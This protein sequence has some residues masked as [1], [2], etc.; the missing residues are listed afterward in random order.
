MIEAAWAFAVLVLLAAVTAT[1]LVPWQSLLEIGQGV[2]LSASAVG[3]PLEIV[4]FALLGLALRVNGGA[5]QGWYWRSFLHHHLLTPSQRRWVL[6]WFY[7]GA[8]AFLCIG[9]GI[10]LVVLAFV[11]AFRQ[12]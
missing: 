4:Y 1:V 9:L 12:N 5:P 11:A 2:M 10:V 7:A 8:F 3:I 6:P